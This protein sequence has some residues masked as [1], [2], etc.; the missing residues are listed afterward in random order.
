M[1]FASPD[2]DENIL[3]AL[4]Q[5]FQVELME[6][7]TAQGDPL[8]LKTLKQSDLQDDPTLVAPY[9]TYR[10]D[11]D[12]GVMPPTPEQEKMYGGHEIGGPIL[13]IHYYDAKFGTPLATDRASQRRAIGILSSRVQS[14]LIKFYDLAG[15]IA[16]GALESPDQSKVIEGA[17]PYLIDRATTRIFGGETTFYGEGRIYWHYP[18]RWYQQYRVLTTQ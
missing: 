3:S 2:I 15:V 17:S 10:P 7:L 16:D 11:I 4:Q 8:T 5:V 13:F 18:V 6:Y 12:K 9:L 1:T 14:V